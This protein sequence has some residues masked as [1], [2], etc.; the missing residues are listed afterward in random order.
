MQQIERMIAKIYIFLLPIRMITPL[1]FLQNYVGGCAL[2]LDFVFHM[3]GL[4]L[5]FV[6]GG[7]IKFEQNTKKIWG[8][9]LGIVGIYTILNMWNAVF[10]HNMLGVVYGEDSFRATTGSII[11]WIHYASIATYNLR[12]FQLLGADKIWKVLDKLSC[13][14]AFVGYFQ[15]LLIVT[16]NTIL[17]KLYDT[18]AS[19][20]LFMSSSYLLKE[21]RITLTTTE[22]AHAGYIIVRLILPLLLAYMLTEGLNRKLLIK[23]V[24]WLPIIYFTQSSN[25]YILVGVELVIFAVLL[26]WKLV[27][28]KRIFLNVYSGT[29]LL[30]TGVLCALIP[31]ILEKVDVSK[32][33]YIVFQK[34]TDKTNMSTA[35]RVAPLYINWEIFKDF[36]ILGIGN[37][38]Q[39]FFYWEHFPNW[40]YELL[41]GTKTMEWNSGELSNGLL[42]FPSILSGYGIVGILLIIFFITI[43][44]M[45][46]W[47][48]RNNRR[49]EFA[50]FIIAVGGVIVN[51]FSSDFVGCYDVWFIM[52]IPFL[53]S[54]VGKEEMNK[55]GRIMYSSS[56]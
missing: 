14:M 15:I 12:V 3:L 18:V 48:Q 32:L 6:N 36:P 39:G 16:R 34:I 44:I 47:S 56:E 27:K 10:Y 38:N 19:D 33:V 30:V 5:W 2:N 28:S 52:S 46:M 11:Y 23:I 24:T 42:F 41:A 26:V 13:C 7:K 21:N 37:G 1:A 17:C 8:L 54:K 49:R 20:A 29:V 31:Y 55:N 22:P 53:Y 51:G 25:A 4:F 9:F 43:A 50:F 40:A 35:W 45:Y